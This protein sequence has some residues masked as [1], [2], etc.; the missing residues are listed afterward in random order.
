[1]M[2]CKFW[3]PWFHCP[4][5]QFFENWTFRITVGDFFLLHTFCV[6][7]N[8]FSFVLL[9]TN[10]SYQFIHKLLLLV[11]FFAEISASFFEMISSKVLIYNNQL[12]L[13]VDFNLL[14]ISASFLGGVLLIALKYLLVGTLSVDS[15]NKLSGRPP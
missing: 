6:G 11:F 12:F 4:I 5:L 1:M 14:I 7:L 8:P 2:S 15:E 3:R 9:M 13:V 10:R